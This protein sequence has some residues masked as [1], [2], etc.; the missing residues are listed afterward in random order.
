[1]TAR[2]ERAVFALLLLNLGLQVFDGIATYAGLR[3]GFGEGNPLLAGAMT[4]LGP[5]LAL[6]LTKLSACACLLG[7]WHARRARLALP[8][9]VIAAAVYATCSLAPWSAALMQ[10]QLEPLRL[11]QL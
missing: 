7:V 1:M 10:A 4:N 2:A 6:G 5:A 9:L 11:A 8:A 3:L